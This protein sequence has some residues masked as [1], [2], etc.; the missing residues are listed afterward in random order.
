[1]IRWTLRLTNVTRCGGSAARAYATAGPAST[2]RSSRTGSSRG[3][4]AG[5]RCHPRPANRPG[6]GA[7]ARVGGGHGGILAGTAGAHNRR[8]AW[9][10][11]PAAFDPPAQL[12][13]RSPAGRPVWP[14]P[15]ACRRTA[16]HGP[17]RARPSRGCRRSRAAAGPGSARSPSSAAPAARSRPC[18]AAACACAAARGWSRCPARTRR[19]ARPA[20]RPR[21]RRSSRTPS[22]SEARPSRRALTSVPISAMPASYVSTTA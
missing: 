18:A 9:T 21:R 6:P 5:A 3:P 19:C 1:M 4:P 22:T 11:S 2:S 12:A 15:A 13:G 20:A 10:G 17:A 14:G 16:C 7:T 8:S